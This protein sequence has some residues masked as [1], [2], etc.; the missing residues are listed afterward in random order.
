MLSDRMKFWKVFSSLALG[1]LVFAASA[2]AAPRCEA[3]LDPLAAARLVVREAANLPG[4]TVAR[5]EQHLVRMLDGKVIAELEYIMDNRVVMDVFRGKVEPEFRRQ[6]LHRL[7]IAQA[8]LAQPQTERLTALLAWSNADMFYSAFQKLSASERIFHPRESELKALTAT[9]FYKI[10]APFG[11]T[12][13]VRIRQM[14]DA[15]DVTI[16]RPTLTQD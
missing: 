5:S 12:K 7:L 3:L 11:F 2:G 13:V 4:E 6:G 16:E 10:V 8:L 14:K 15:V 1:L 9:S